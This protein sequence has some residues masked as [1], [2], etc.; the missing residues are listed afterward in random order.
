MVAA[1]AVNA[2]LRRIHEDVFFE[3]SL[4]NAL[5]DVVLLQKWLARRFVLYEFDAEQQAEP[6]DIADVWMR[7]QRSEPRFHI[8]ARRHHAIDQL[9][10]LEVIEHGVASCCSYRMRLIRE[11]VLEC[12]RTSLEGGDYV[13][14]NDHGTQ[15]GV[16][17]G[18]SLPCQNH[19]RLN[20][21]VLDSEWLSSSAH[22]G[23]H[24]ISDQ[25]NAATPADFGDALRVPVRRSHSAE[26]G[27]DDRLEKKGGN[28][29]FIVAVEIG[30]E[31]AGTFQSVFSERLAVRSVKWETRRDV[32]HSASIGW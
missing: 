8:F 1:F 17:A 32:P 19:V 13:W 25:Q 21:P 27:A 15:R 24:F 12:R 20:V 2:A 30:I 9:V 22:T 31:I 10:L 18:N 28:A 16:A 5:G 6:A 23:H 4:A 14:C 29:F 11:A 7:E 26:R 3:C